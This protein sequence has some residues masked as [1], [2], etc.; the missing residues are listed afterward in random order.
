MKIRSVAT[1][2]VQSDERTDIT[3]LTVAFR[4]SANAL[5]K[6]LTRIYTPM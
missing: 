4:N 2:L 6:I 3:Q 5:N 1:K